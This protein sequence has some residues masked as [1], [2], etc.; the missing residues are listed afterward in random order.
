[1]ITALSISLILGYL[2]MIAFS[3]GIYW[4]DR[5]EKEPLHLLVFSFLWGAVIAAMAAFIINTLLGAGIY[6]L[7]ASTGT[8]TFSVAS[9]FAPIVEEVFKGI[10]VL[11]V[12]L[13]FRSEFDSILD[14]IIYAAVTALGFAATENAYYIFSMGYAGGGWQ[15]LFQLAF[16]RIVL[17]GWQHPFY[18]A[19]FGIGLALA[20]TQKSFFIKFFAPLGGLMLAIITH[21][22][23]NTISPLLIYNAGLQGLIRAS[24]LDWFGWGFMLI[25]IIFMIRHEETIMKN[26]LV[27]EIQHNIITQNQYLAAVSHNHR[28]QLKTAASQQEK[29]GEKLVADLCQL[30]AELAHKKHQYRK[31]GNE[32]GNLAIIQETRKRLLTVS[33]QLRKFDP[34]AVNAD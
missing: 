12:F 25:F 23:H 3:Y 22:L 14:G 32:L 10:A 30:S 1:M 15:G 8:A 11:I 19:F 29:S 24:Q 26:H 7:T 20:R 34:P 16:I 4:L 2:P 33:N 9:I 5:Y 27:D 31:H 21:S 17:V 13:F 6:W 28:K 18:T